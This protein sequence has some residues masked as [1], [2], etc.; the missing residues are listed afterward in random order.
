M[1]PSDHSKQ[2]WN[3]LVYWE[4]IPSPHSDKNLDLK[5]KCSIPTEMINLHSVTIFWNLF[6]AFYQIEV[7]EF[8]EKFILK[9][10]LMREKRIM[11]TL[12]DMWAP[13]WHKTF[14]NK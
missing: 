13:M 5:F 14:I 1:S 12:C 3:S 10:R 2:M 4:F 8:T 6:V 11:F 9:D 7:I